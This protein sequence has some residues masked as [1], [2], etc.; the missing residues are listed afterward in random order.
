MIPISKDQLGV[1]KAGETGIQVRFVN[2]DG[3]TEVWIIPAR[4]LNLGDLRA[5]VLMAGIDNQVDVRLSNQAEII[6]RMTQHV[7]Y[8]HE[9]L[10]QRTAEECTWFKS[11]DGK[12]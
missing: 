10:G 5:E 3:K 11:R 4:A 8:H 2:R 12:M 6:G 1:M 9:E 7:E